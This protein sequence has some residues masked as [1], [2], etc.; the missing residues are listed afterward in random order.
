MSKKSEFQ[1]VQDYWY[2]KLKD[3]GFDDIEYQ[4]GSIKSAAPR[5][6]GSMDPILRE[7]TQ[8]YYYMAHHFLNSYKFES[9][10][11]RV[12]WDYHTNGI[13]VRNIARLLKE[14]GQPKMKKSTV[15]NIL[16]ELE[17]KMK[18]LYLAP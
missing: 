17:T 3:E 14:A 11:E 5:S 6:I 15:W 16:R 10:M 4:G 8:E 13:S 1:R 18:A 7:A 12:L 9:E 2:A